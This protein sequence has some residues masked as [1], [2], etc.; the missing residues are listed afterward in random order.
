MR[1]LYAYRPDIDG[2]RALAII[3]V[4]CFHAFPS[5]LSGGFI[6]VDVFFVISGF[7][8]TQILNQQ[9]QQANFSL[10]AFYSGRIRRL[11]PALIVVLSACCAFGWAALLADEYRH[12]GKLTVASTL[13]ASNF[14]LWSE[15]GAWG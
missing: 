2:L 15:F 1:P 13:F 3:A 7:L 5:Y 6:G 8:I 9:R 4:I 14:V 12:V 11:F 10:S